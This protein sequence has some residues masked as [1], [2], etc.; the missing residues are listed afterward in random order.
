LT[1]VIGLGS[2][3]APP[4]QASDADL[5]K[6]HSPV[7][8]MFNRPTIRSQNPFPTGRTDYRPSRVDAFLAEAI[9]IPDSIPNLLQSPVASA[10]SGILSAGA[11]GSGVVR[12]FLSL[13]DGAAKILSLA[14]LD[15]PPWFFA[16]SMAFVLFGVV[17][18]VSAL[19]PFA[20]G[21][22]LGAVMLLLLPYVIPYFPG[23]PRTIAAFRDAAANAAG[24]SGSILTLGYAISRR[25]IWRRYLRLEPALRAPA[26]YGRVV[27]EPTGR[28]VL[29]YWCFYVYNDWAN[30]HEADFE[31]AMVFIPAGTETPNR[32]VLSS[33]EGGTWRSW[34]RTTRMNDE[35]VVADAG[36]HP[37]AYVARGS[38]A[39]YFEARPGG[40]RPPLVRQIKTGI[41]IGRFE[42]TTDA[43]NRRL[44]DRVAPM[45][46]SRLPIP[47]EQY[48][49]VVMPREVPR[50]G[51]VGWNDFWWLGWRGTWGRR[52]GIPGPAMQG[53]KWTSPTTWAPVSCVHDAEPFDV[54][55]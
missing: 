50:P 23:W 30:T 5:L 43:R 53:T 37:V 12:L 2:T 54:G 16:G 31:V 24:T 34:S 36:T 17:A 7:L 39:M 40:Y 27:Q 35:G 3:T 18:L 52:D 21:V 1:A 6:T 29:Q 20:V 49:L 9:E 15:I 25:A 11:V 22:A 44:K 38:H 4:E 41:G 45:P 51:S 55:R 46:A 10:V 32:V 42:L 8:V 48:E 28:R 13:P 19:D 47:G 33:H 26:V 14:G